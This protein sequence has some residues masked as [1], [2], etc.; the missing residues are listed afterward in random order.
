MEST[1]FLAVV[2]SYECAWMTNATHMV[3]IFFVCADVAYRE[4]NVTKKRKKA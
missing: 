4:R 1:P 2:V 3:R